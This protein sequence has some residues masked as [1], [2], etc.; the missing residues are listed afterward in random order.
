[1]TLGGSGAGSSVV[2]ERSDLLFLLL[3]DA[4]LNFSDVY[5]C[6]I[7]FF[8]SVDAQSKFGSFVRRRKDER[9]ESVLLML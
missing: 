2:G 7:Y 9:S 3:P 1:M 4:V 8:F 5:L 6:G